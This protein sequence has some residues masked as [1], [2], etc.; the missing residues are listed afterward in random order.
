M[1]DIHV[2]LKMKF[3]EAANKEDLHTKQLYVEAYSHRENLKF[4]GLAEKVVFEKVVL[5][6]RQML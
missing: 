1:E 4:F 3:L 2:K 6:S 5:K